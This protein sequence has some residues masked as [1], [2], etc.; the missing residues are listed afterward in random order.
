MVVTKLAVAFIAVNVF[1]RLPGK[2]GVTSAQKQTPFLIIVLHCFNLKIY[3]FVRKLTKAK[4]QN[5]FQL[6]KK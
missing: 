1:Q 4:I 2:N 3:A 6:A 5:A